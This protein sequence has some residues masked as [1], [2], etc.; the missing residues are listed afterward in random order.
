MGDIILGFL[1]ARILTNTILGQLSIGIIVRSR[2]SLRE[3][4]LIGKI[5]SNSKS[6]LLY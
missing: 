2:R 5:H 4:I 3:L 1:Y 6:I